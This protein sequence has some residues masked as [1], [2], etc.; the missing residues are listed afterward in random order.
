MQ[1]DPADA[2]F[3][4]TT[5]ER[6]PADDQT[7]RPLTLELNG[8]VVVRARKDEQSPMMELLL[9]RSRR[10]GEQLRLQTNRTYLARALELGF[11]EVGFVDAQSPCVCRDAT[12]TYVWMLLENKGALEP[13]TEAMQIDSLSVPSN[14]TAIGRVA[15][16]GLAKAPRIG[17][18]TAN[19]VNSAS[20][21]ARPVNRIVGQLESR[22]AAKTNRAGD[23]VPVPSAPQVDVIERTLEL[24]NQLRTIVQGLG[25]LVTQI[26]QQRKQTRLM[27]STLQSL[28][29]LQLLEA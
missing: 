6:L 2:R 26:R 25:E 19:P 23:V 8:A 13:S 21:P 7:D 22:A 20:N 27:K 12:R 15:G 16:D 9:S 18:T 24:R 11:T 17:V 5:V 4:T 14:G 3:L 10:V 1:V 28:K 29:Q